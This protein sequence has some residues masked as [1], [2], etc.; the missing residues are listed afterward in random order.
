[1]VFTRKGT[2]TA[3]GQT[4]KREHADGD[5]AAKRSKAK[6]GMAMA[7]KETASATTTKKEKPHMPSQR[8]MSKKGYGPGET[9]FGIRFTHPDK[10]M[11]PKAKLT[12]ANLAQYY[13]DIGNFIM[14]YL[15]DRPL[16]IVR[17]IRG[18]T[19]E[20]Q[21]VQRHP[22]AGLHPTMKHGKIKQKDG[23][24]LEY[25]YAEEAMALVAAVQMDTVEFHAWQ[26][27]FQSPNH[28]DQLV[29]D[30]DPGEGVTF[31]TLVEVA[32]AMRKVLE[33]EF[34]L[35]SFIMLTGSVGLHIVCPLHPP[36]KTFDVT[37]DFA[38]GVAYFLE[39]AKPSIVTAK[40][41]KPSRIGKVFIDY[42]RNSYNQTSIVPYSTRARPE[43]PV[44]TPV[45]WSELDSIKAPNQFTTKT[46]LERVR[47]A[48]FK[49]P[50]KGFGAVHQH[51]PQDWRDTMSKLLS[52][53]P[54]SSSSSA[55]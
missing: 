31:S 42:I 28:P 32:R 54:G 2:D 8:Q 39:V 50:W 36:E 4:A 9:M 49:D 47:S 6:G 55:H 17:G 25:M 30:L 26:A 44:A 5:K 46:V 53:A 27:K 40:P 3:T 15:N 34:H 38:K 12:K 14:P 48:S 41:G 43:A 51:I 21:F 1:M 22:P 37:H 20:R 35:K 29:F 23:R 11:F 10:V 13:L 19:D 16:T 52:S 45:D 33:D 24:T 18:A 7:K